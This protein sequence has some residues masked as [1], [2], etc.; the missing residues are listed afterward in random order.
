MLIRTYGSDLL[1]FSYARSS[2]L[3]GL[4][5]VLASGGYSSWGAQASHFSL[6]W[7]LLFWS[8]DSRE[9]AQ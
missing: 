2:F 8:R 6:Q 5:I 9:L 7:L 4:S 3:H 1:I